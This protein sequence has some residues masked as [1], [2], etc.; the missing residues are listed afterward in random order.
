[1]IRCTGVNADLTTIPFASELE[2]MAGFALATADLL[3]QMAADDYVDKLPILFEE[4][5]E[6]ARHNDGKMTG[7]GSFRSARDLME[8][9]PLF[10]ERYVVPKIARD[11]H[12][13]H[14]YLNR[15]YPNGAN[16]YLKR[17]EANL[18]RLGRQLAAS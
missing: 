4:F 16:D 13:L 11:F 17:I 1:M 8:K 14:Q 12:N 2:R 18:E 9:T 15:P 6:S 3:G 10:W 7:A 5:T